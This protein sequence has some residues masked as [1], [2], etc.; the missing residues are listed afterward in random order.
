[1]AV[2]PNRHIPDMKEYE[3][4]LIQ[5]SNVPKHKLKDNAYIC[6]TINDLSVYTATRFTNLHDSSHFGYQYLAFLKKEI[7][8][9]MLENPK[10]IKIEETDE[11]ILDNIIFTEWTCIWIEPLTSSMY[12]HFN[13]MVNSFKLTCKLENIFMN[14]VSIQTD[15]IN[16]IDHIWYGFNKF[17]CHINKMAM[18]KLKKRQLKN[19]IGNIWY[20]SIHSKIEVDEEIIESDW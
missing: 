19:G 6:Q 5:M 15:N 8:Q 16:P 13:D 10:H 9:N 2:L 1:M 12:K 17:P 20:D 18:D 7:R 14:S 4:I 3:Y 11:T